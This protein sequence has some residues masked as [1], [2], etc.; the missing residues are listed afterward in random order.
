[1]NITEKEGRKLLKMKLDTLK[2]LEKAEKE[3]RMQPRRAAGGV[4]GA[5]KRVFECYALLDQIN[6]MLQ[7]LTAK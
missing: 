5:T 7:E 4:T 1:M 6:S 2:A 3:E